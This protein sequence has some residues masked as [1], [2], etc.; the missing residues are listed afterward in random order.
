MHVP[1]APFWSWITGSDKKDETPAKPD[2]ETDKSDEDLKAPIS[3]TV[4]G[5]SGEDASITSADAGESQKD[6]SEEGDGVPPEEVS[7]KAADTTDGLDDKN[8][9][10]P[11]E[12]EPIKAADSP[13]VP[14][15]KADGTSSEEFAVK[16]TE[17]TDDL[18]EKADGI[19]PK[20]VSLSATDSTDVGGEADGVPS[21]ETST[22]TTILTEGLDKKDN[23]VPQEDM[24]TKTIDSTVGLD[25]KDH[26][27]SSEKRGFASVIQENRATKNGEPIV[28]DE[29]K[30]GI[31]TKQDSTGGSKKEHAVVPPEEVIRTGTIKWISFKGRYGIIAQDKQFRKLGVKSMDAFFFFNEIYPEIREFVPLHDTHLVTPIINTEQRRIQFQARVHERDGKQSL[32][33]FNIRYTTPFA[34]RSLVTQKGEIPM[35]NWPA[36]LTLIRK[37]K[38]RL[39]NDIHN[40]LSAPQIDE[41]DKMKRTHN[42]LE[43]CNK[44]I[45]WM[46]SQVTSE[47]VAKGC[48]AKL[49]DEIYDMLSDIANVDNVERRA[50]EAYFRCLSDLSQFGVKL[51]QNQEEDLKGWVERR[52]KFE[53]RGN[54]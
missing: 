31:P 45:E 15:E 39:G 38:A 13:D 33:A 10:V 41:K 9:V 46:R 20:E 8:D 24:S 51:T 28:L 18:S 2:P 1:T 12:V 16:S 23:S 7:G 52:A 40:I 30:G 27:I 53:L 47:D 19:P 29:K 34:R 42:A 48:K 49:G 36:A 5:G 32:R 4:L 44:K 43:H 11:P 14:E 26:G 3:D 17:S 37:S 35:L 50:D 22:E 6:K 21:E 54:Y 25:E